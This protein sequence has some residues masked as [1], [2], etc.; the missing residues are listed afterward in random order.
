VRPLRSNCVSSDTIYQG[1]V[2]SQT[3][4]VSPRNSDAL[5]TVSI[6]GTFLKLFQNKIYAPWNIDEN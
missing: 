2:I 6:S 5:E 1:S 3:L 4:R